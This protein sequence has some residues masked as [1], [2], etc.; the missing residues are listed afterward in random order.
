MIGELILLGI[1]SSVSSQML[2][3]MMT[4]EE[5]NK[6]FSVY[7]CTEVPTYDV[8][9]VSISKPRNRRMSD[10]YLIQ[11]PFGESKRMWLNP[12]DGILADKNLPVYSIKSNSSDIHNPII[13]YHNLSEH[14]L[15]SIYENTLHATTVAVNNNS[16]GGLTLTGFIGDS[17]IHPVPDRLQE[18]ARKRRSV[19]NKLDYD[20]D[21]QIDHIIYKIPANA[22]ESRSLPIEI[23][24]ESK[25]EFRSKRST[26]D[27]IYPEILVIVEHTLNK[28]MGETLV[29]KILHLLSF[30]NGVD[31]RYRSFE[32]PRIR[33]RIVR[34]VLA[35]DTKV[36][37][38]MKVDPQNIGLL[39][40]ENARRE[41]GNWLYNMQHKFPFDTYDI[42]V[43]MLTQGLCKTSNTSN[44][45]TV[46]TT[47]I[48]GAC[49]VSKNNTCDRMAFVQER[50]AFDGIQTAAHEL[51]HLMG[52][53]HDLE[54]T[55]K[56][57]DDNGYV[58]TTY[59]RFS[60]HSFDWSPCSISQMDKFI[61][62]KK[63]SCLYNSP[64]SGEP[65]PRYL[66]GR[67]IDA[68]QQCKMI[69][70]GN[71]T[72]IDD[73]ICTQLKCSKKDKIALPEAAEGTPCGPDK[74]CLHGQCIPESSVV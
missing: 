53:M 72:V 61:R 63:A 20:S 14:F 46:G 55:G 40:Y 74:L 73:S 42:A 68:N 25:T 36:L 56:C 47:Y 10:S 24:S 2:H 69:V 13:T 67:R 26:I 15:P 58:M 7:N 37:P 31:M 50:A 33:I 41:Q 5:L 70:N 32:N 9:P 12:I 30:W 28:L 19:N 4:P 18:H 38:Y 59:N 21:D 6:I 23:P 1:I 65:F 71:A 44:C 54:K 3:Q 49:H 11:K 45:N 27:I 64:R 17:Y 22:V 66:P 16:N 8:V 62:S 39:Y 29:D 51:G 34:V 48:N 57:Q 52:A 60:S 43:T 35:E